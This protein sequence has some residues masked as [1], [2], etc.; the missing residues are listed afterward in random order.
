MLNYKSGRRWR[1]SVRPGK[2]SKRFSVEKETKGDEKAM[3]LAQGQ[4]QTNGSNSVSMWTGT[5]STPPH[6]SVLRKV[7]TTSRSSSLIAFGTPL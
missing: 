2:T 6:R 1:P 5:Q 7:A 4:S 3:S